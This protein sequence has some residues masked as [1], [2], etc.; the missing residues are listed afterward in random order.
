VAAEITS[1]YQWLL[2]GGS[3][4]SCVTL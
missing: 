4:P 1:V 3:P 2:N